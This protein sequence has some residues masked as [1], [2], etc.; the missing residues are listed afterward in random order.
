MELGPGTLIGGKY[1]IERPLAKGGMGSVWV[2]RH[3]QLGS[4]VAIKFLDASF[5]ASDRKSVV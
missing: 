3:E 1:R 2:A 4:A 5:A